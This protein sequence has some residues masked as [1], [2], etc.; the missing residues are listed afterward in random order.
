MKEAPPAE[1]AAA[2]MAAMRRGDWEEAWRQTDRIELPRRARQGQRGFVRDPQHLRWDGTRFEGRR[3]LVR[4][5]HGLGDTL[6]F[7]RFVPQLAAIAREVHVMMQPALLGLFAGAPQLGTVHNGWTEWWPPPPHEVEVEVMELPYALRVTAQALPLPYRLPRAR[8][9]GKLPVDL[10][11]DGTLRVGLLWAA[12]DW[13]ASRSV[14]LERLAPLLRVQ[15][16]RCFSFQQGDAGADPLVAQFG[17]QPLSR[18]TADVLAAAT[19]LL[20]MDVVITVDNMMAHLAG[21]LG[22]PTW[23]LLKHEADW[24]WMD[25]RSDSPWYPAMRLFRQTRPGDWEEVVE[26][27]AAALAEMGADPDSRACRLPKTGSGPIS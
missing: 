2:W 12:S 8:F 25:G 17:I 3:V 10:P 20:E 23:V 22:R 4:C 1:V 18:H 19:A 7:I 15:G 14:T 16:A 5:E 11:R 21:T 6:Q 26:R 27:A 13:D 24:R 9:A